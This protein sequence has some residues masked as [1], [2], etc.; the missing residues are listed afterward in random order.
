MSDTKQTQSR[1]PALVKANDA[2]EPY[3]AA[4]SVTY[5][6][7]GGWWPLAKS[8][9]AYSSNPKPTLFDRFIK[10]LRKCD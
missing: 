1:A 7:G 4:Q 3:F 10:G 9:A 8:A 2:L 5:A 6:I